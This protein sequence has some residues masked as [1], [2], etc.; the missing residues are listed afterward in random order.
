MS[1]SSLIYRQS[2]NGV[3]VYPSSCIDPGIGILTSGNKTLGTSIIL[4]VPE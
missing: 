3:S 1:P 2:L 4:W